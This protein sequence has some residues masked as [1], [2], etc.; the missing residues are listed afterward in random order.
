VSAGSGCDDLGSVKVLLG[1]RIVVESPLRLIEIPL[2]R[3]I[4]GRE[5][6][7]DVVADV[8]P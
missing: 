5:D 7:V 3:R 6:I 1:K 2:A 4:E 8:R